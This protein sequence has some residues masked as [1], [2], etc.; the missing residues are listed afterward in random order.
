MNRSRYGMQL[1]PYFE[2]FPVEQIHLLVF[3]E[4]VA[5]PSGSLKDIAG[6]LGIEPDA[7]RVRRPRG[8]ARV[9]RRVPP[10][11]PRPR[12]S[13]AIPW[14]GASSRRCRSPCAAWPARPS[15]PPSSRSRR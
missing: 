14:A 15:A 9:D 6:F 8:A 13:S 10:Q 7:F 1:R 12:A 3:E 4:H 5:D 11:R 2:R